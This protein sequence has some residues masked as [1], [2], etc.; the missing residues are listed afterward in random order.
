VE[1]V[2]ELTT[3][4]VPPPAMQGS[5]EAGVTAPPFE[6]TALPESASRPE[7]PVAAAPAGESRLRVAEVAFGRGVN[8][9]LLEGPGEVFQENERVYCYSRIL[10]GANGQTVQ[11][12]WIFRDREVQTIDLTVK[13]DDWRTWSYKTLFPGLAGDWAVEIRD[14]EGRP[15]GRYSF[16]CQP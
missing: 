4:T 8:N 12:I 15:L 10:G 16:I 14:S 5:A 7:D 11:H 6:Q 2:E 3:K 9:R 13:S 1:Q